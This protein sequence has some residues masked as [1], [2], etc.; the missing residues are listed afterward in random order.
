MN[1][2]TTNCGVNETFSITEQA[3]VDL[4]TNSISDVKNVK[5][6]AEPRISFLDDK[7][8]VSFVIDIKVK[9][10]TPLKDAIENL[11]NELTNQFKTLLSFE[12]KSL[13]ICFISFF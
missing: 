9:R 8:N 6:A 13:R 3:F 2:L 1:L 7:S 4:I 10:N 5:L 11:K 12:P